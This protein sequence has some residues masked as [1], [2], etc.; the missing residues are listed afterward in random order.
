MRVPTS[1]SRDQPSAQ[2]GGAPRRQRPQ[3][4]R[5]PRQGNRKPQWTLAPPHQSRLVPPVQP[6]VSATLD[7]TARALK[8]WL[9]GQAIAMLLVKACT[10]LG[11][12]LIGVARSHCLRYQRQAFWQIID[13][14]KS[15]YQKQSY[16]HLPDAPSAETTLLSHKSQLFAKFFLLSHLS[17]QSPHVRNDRQRGQKNDA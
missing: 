13:H 17:L 2:P 12:W 1:R 11:L 5:R 16:C 10:A 15:S 9:A 6:N 14:G 3:R 8:G 7:D 4:L